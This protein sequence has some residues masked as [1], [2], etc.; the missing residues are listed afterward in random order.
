MLKSAIKTLLL[1]ISLGFMTCSSHADC[2]SGCC[3]I[4]QCDLIAAAPCNAVALGGPCSDNFACTSYFCQENTCN[5]QSLGICQEHSQCLS[6]YC[7]NGY[8]GLQA[9]AVSAAIDA[10]CIAH[11][12]CSSNYCLEKVCKSK[13]VE[14]SCKT[15]INCRREA[16]NEYGCCLNDKCILNAY[17]PNQPK[18][19]SC[20]NGFECISFKCTKNKCGDPRIAYF[21]LL[22]IGIPMGAVFAVFWGVYITKEVIKYKKNTNKNESKNVSV[23]VV[24]ALNRIKAS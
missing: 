8:C 24:N 22:V 20:E 14:P 10:A 5:Y 9:E 7:N 18:D 13:P 1:I 16:S 19:T 3:N 11:S 21:Y 17:C 12:D 15:H 23:K 2:A 6:G 4:D